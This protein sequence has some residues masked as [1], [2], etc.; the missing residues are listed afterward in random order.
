MSYYSVVES[1]TNLYAIQNGIGG[2]YGHSSR[3]TTSKVVLRHDGCVV[4]NGAHGG[5]DRTIYRR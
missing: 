2:S 1:W 4:R 3:C 5:S